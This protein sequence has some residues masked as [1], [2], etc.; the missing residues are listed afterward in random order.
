MECSFSSSY[1]QPQASTSDILG[2][3]Q[4]PSGWEISY[5]IICGYLKHPWLPQVGAWAL[6]LERDLLWAAKQQLQGR[7]HHC[8]LWALEGTGK[9]FMGTPSCWPAPPHRGSH[10]QACHPYFCPSIKQQPESSRAQRHQTDTQSTWAS[11]PHTSTA[12]LGQNKQN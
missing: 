4:N 10:L 9:G 3:S 5:E 7:R 6:L 12:S 11:Q 2:T 1:P 8:S